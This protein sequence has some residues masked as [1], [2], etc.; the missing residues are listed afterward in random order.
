MDELSEIK[1]Y[2]IPHSS[3]T[4]CQYSVLPQTP[5]PEETTVEVGKWR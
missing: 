4:V 1:Q 5:L 3:D 2:Q